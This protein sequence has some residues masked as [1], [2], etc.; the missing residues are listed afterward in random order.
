M[1]HG[2]GG[3]TQFLVPT[4]V[5]GGGIDEATVVQVA[6]GQNHAMA[7]T[8]AGQLFAWG[9]GGDGQ[10]GH[11]GKED[12]SVPRVV[13]GIEGTVVGMSGGDIHSLVT[14]AEGRVLVFYFNN[15]SS[16]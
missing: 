6:A 12:L 15:S 7:L 2:G 8:T 4:K 10:L 1:G 5:T 3:A 11:G 16:I 13:D 9:T 14:T